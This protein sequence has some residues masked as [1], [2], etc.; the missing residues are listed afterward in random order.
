MIMHATRFSVVLTAGACLL[1]GPNTSDAEETGD[2][3]PLPCIRPVPGPLCGEGIPVLQGFIVCDG[4]QFD[5]FQLERPRT[6][7]DCEPA[8]KGWH[9]CDPGWIAPILV[10]YACNPNDPLHPVVVQEVPW[11]DICPT[12]IVSSAV[13]GT[14]P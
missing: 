4:Y 10:R 14:L 1:V 11:G 7:V 2:P 9:H 13:C 5:E 12:F 6:F 3:Q 8:Q